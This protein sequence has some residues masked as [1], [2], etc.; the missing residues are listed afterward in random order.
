ML[1]I[2][3]CQIVSF[4]KSLLWALFQLLYCL[5]SCS[6]VTTFWC[7]C[8]VLGCLCSDRWIWWDM[9]RLGLRKC[10]SINFNGTETSPK[11]C[12]FRR[13]V[14]EEEYGTCY[15]KA[16]PAWH[17]DWG[18]E[19]ALQRKVTLLTW[20]R[21]CKVSNSH[22]GLYCQWCLESQID[23]LQLDESLFNCI[24]EISWL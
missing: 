11:K 5:S 18:A 7:L 17:S 20:S 9:C 14:L 8:S 1:F 12:E 15:F 2:R 6:V 10:S 4:T 16:G 13:F 22:Y 3:P 19:R 23:T 21:V 24:D